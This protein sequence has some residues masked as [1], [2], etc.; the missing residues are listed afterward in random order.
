MKKRI[1]TLIDFSS[2]SENL[3]NFTDSLADITKSDILLIHQVPII[4]PVLSDDNS[5]KEIIELEKNEALKKLKDLAKERISPQK[6]IKYLVT[7]KPL[8]VLLPEIGSYDSDDLVLAGLKGTGILKKIFLGSTISKII[9]DLNLVTIAVPLRT[10]DF[11]PEKLI[12]GIN[13]R[14]PLNKSKLDHLLRTLDGCVQELEFISVITQDDKESDTLKYIKQLSE[15]Y[16]IKVP[17]TNYKI[18]SGKNAFEEIK[19][20]MPGDNKTFL[21]LQKGTRSLNDQVF[22]KFVVNDL[23]YHGTVPL[24]IL[25]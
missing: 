15:D 18:F 11:K 23:I 5:R 22:R 21:V 7:Q 12:I 19:N 13:Y 2:Y 1:I 25:P 17:N 16:R 24:I 6:N 10:K 14:Y 20:F 4:V 8:I 3:L 9:D